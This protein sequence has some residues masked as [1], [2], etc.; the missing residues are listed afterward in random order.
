MPNVHRIPGPV[1]SF[2]RNLGKPT[3][4]GLCGGGHGLQ[5]AAEERGVEYL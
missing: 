2:R 1:C 5:S 3:P 4:K